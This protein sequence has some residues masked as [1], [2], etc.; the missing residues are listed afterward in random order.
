LIPEHGDLFPNVPAPF[1]IE[2]SANKFPPK[3][4][5]ENTRAKGGWALPIV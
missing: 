4:K 5:I 2:K 3:W 1:E